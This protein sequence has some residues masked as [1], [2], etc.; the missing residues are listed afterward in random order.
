MLRFRTTTAP[1]KDR[2]IKRYTKGRRKPP[3]LFAHFLSASALQITFKVTSA[4]PGVTQLPP[5][6]RR[7]HLSSINQNIAEKRPATLLEGVT[8][9]KDTHQSEAT[10]KAIAPVR[11]HRDFEKPIAAR[12]ATYVYL[13]WCLFSCWSLRIC[14]VCALLCSAH[15]RPETAR[16]RFR[17]PWRQ[18]PG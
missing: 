13:N 1:S 2:T 18:Y 7:G 10:R 16:K 15:T 8:H 4:Y 12:S 14:S 6:N 5:D 3:F 17:G 9:S 11:F